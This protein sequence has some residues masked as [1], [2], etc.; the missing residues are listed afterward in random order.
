MLKPEDTLLRDFPSGPAAKTFA[1]PMHGTWLDP[2]SG[3]RLPRVAIKSETPQL[4][5]KEREKPHVS[6]DPVKAT[7]LRPGSA[8]KAK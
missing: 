3:T 6:T 8:N 5:K 1:F 4:K 7:K 2:R